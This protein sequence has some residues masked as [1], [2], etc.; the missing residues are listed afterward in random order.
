MKGLGRLDEAAAPERWLRVGY[1]SSDFRDHAVGRNV[2]PL[3]SSHDGSAFEVFC[4][5]DVRRPDAMTERFQS[6]V[7]HWR[8]I[9]GKSDADVAGMVRADGIDVLV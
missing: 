3:I 1:L 6:C 2:F 7:D 8:S 5:A 9:T 4:Y